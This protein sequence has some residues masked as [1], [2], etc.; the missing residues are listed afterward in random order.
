ARS[1]PARLSALEAFENALSVSA[2]DTRP[3]VRNAHR[4]TSAGTAEAQADD[5]A[6]RRVTDRVADQVH[7]DLD[8]GALIA[9]CGQRTG[10]IGGG[11]HGSFVC[12]GFEHDHGLSG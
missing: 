6:M 5:A 8:D 11:R 3:F 4:R 2:V 9:A 12:R 1:L 10:P 7:E